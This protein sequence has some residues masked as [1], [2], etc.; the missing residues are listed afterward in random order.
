MSHATLPRRTALKLGAALVGLS[1]FGS[2]QQT[3]RAQI[4]APAQIPRSSQP[5]TGTAPSAGTTVQGTWL[6]QRTEY[7]DDTTVAAPDPT[8]YVLG[9]LADGRLTIQADCNRGT[10]GYTVSGA[11]I[12]IQPGQMTLAACPPGSQDFVFLRDLKQVATFVRDGENLILNMQVDSGNMVFSP[13]PA[14]SLT[15]APWRV[16]SVNN[17]RGSVSSV[18]QGTQ[19]SVTFGEDGNA[20]GET[21]CNTFRGPYTVTDET[22]SFGGLVTTRRACLSEAAGAQEQ[23]FLAALAAS[24]RFELAG[25]RLTLRNDAGATQVTLTR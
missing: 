17:G 23:A 4:S 11:Q 21:G 20:S 13:Q 6:W 12:T 10:G 14:V 8:K 24:T 1:L 3:A 16:L 7:S 2:N 19:L 5:P 22:I 9:L 25:G 15:G 18:V